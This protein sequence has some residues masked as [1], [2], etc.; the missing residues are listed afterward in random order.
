[1][2]VYLASMI[3]VGLKEVFIFLRLRWVGW[4][5]SSVG[6][7]GLCAVFLREGGERRDRLRRTAGVGVDSAKTVERY[8]D[9]FLAY[10]VA[11]VKDVSEVSLVY[12]A[13]EFCTLS[14][15][16]W[17]IVRHARHRRVSSLS[18][19]AAIFALSASWLSMMSSWMLL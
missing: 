9:F 14:W 3:S 16:I 6:I 10:L 1:M 12:G 2:A 4:W 13:W 19:S 8:T 18:V 7:I 15:H 11:L 17:C 5:V